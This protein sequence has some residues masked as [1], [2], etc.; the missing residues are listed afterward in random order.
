M[1][2]GCAILTHLRH[3]AESVARCLVLDIVSAF[4]H[5]AHKRHEARGSAPRASYPYQIERTLFALL[6]ERHGDVQRRAAT[7]W[8]IELSALDDIRDTARDARRE[9][10]VGRHIR[11]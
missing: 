1:S 8:R 4:K 6:N 3:S 2:L 11:A 9:A 5:V 7:T 10:G